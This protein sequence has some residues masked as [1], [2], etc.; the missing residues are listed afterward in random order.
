MNDSYTLRIKSHSSKLE[1]LQRERRDLLSHGNRS[2]LWLKGF[3]QRFRFESLS[4]ETAITLLQQVKIYEGK[5]ICVE[6]ACQDE[7]LGWKHLMA[8]MQK[9]S[10][11][12]T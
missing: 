2:T 1:E 9:G 3:K 5:Q 12:T 11:W 8:E 10:A 4:R 7:Y 6:F